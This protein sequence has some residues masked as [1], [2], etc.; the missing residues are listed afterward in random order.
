LLQNLKNF[1]KTDHADELCNY[2]IKQFGLAINFFEE[3]DLYELKNTKII[4]MLRRQFVDFFEIT[5][6]GLPV[7]KGDFPG[8]YPTNAFIYRFG[9]LATKNVVLIKDE[10]LQPLLKREGVAYSSTTLG[11]QIVRTKKHIIGRGWTRN[12]RLYLD[13]PKIWKQNLCS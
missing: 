13:A 12:G 10:N 7:Y 11:P 9:Q 6:I 2:F 5:Q 1:E 3:F 8:G 4:Y